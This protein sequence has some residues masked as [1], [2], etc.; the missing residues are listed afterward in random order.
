M[1][2]V[3]H[4]LPVPTDLTLTGERTLPGLAV[5]NYWFRRHEAAYRALQP[6]VAGARVLEAGCGEGYGAALLA[7]RAHHVVALDYDA[8]T[9]AHVRAAYPQVAT[10]RGDLQHLPLADA[11]VE[12]VANLQV[13]EHLWDQPGFVAECARVLRPA[14]T[15]LVTTP[16]RLTFSPGLGPGD[17]P[18]NPFHTRELTAGELTALLEPRFT[19]SRMH[20]LRHAA[21]LRRWE[22][23]H[24][25][26]VDAQLA[27]PPESWPPEV[28]RRVEA[29]TVDDFAVGPDDVDGAL[30]L[31]AVAVRRPGTAGR[32]GS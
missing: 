27:G 14:G 12:V 19:L 31:V 24:G 10:V 8:R 30:D 26:L 25:S 23:R 7:E 21:R 20:G 16:N 4:A 28:R 18:L 5:E 11:S 32:A 13:I 22:R 9:A 3:C 2:G 29:V 17:R 15:L 1:R 6:F